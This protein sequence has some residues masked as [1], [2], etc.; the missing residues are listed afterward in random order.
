[1]DEM[2]FFLLGIEEPHDLFVSQVEY[3]D[4]ALP[5][6]PLTETDMTFPPAATPTVQAN[7]PLPTNV[8][9]EQ[10]EDTDPWEDTEPAENTEMPARPLS[11]G[12]LH[13]KPLPHPWHD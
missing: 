2:E 12:P 9:P 10:W 1:M 8:D 11:Q 5:L 13:Q 6:E 3:E 4:T 7:A